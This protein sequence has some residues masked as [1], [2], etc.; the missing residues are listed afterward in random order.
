[1]FIIG[2]IITVIILCIL[3]ILATIFAKIFLKMPRIFDFKD[4]KKT[5]I[6]SKKW[7]DWLEENNHKA[8]YNYVIPRKIRQARYARSHEV[9]FNAIIKEHYYDTDIAEH[10]F[11]Q[12]TLFLQEEPCAKHYYKANDG[13]FFCIT[14]RLGKKDAFSNIP[15]KEMKRILTDEPALYMKY[16]AGADQ[17]PDLQAYMKKEENRKKAEAAKAQAEEQAKAQA[18]AEAA[19]EETAE[20][21]KKKNTKNEEKK[22]KSGL[23]NRFSDLCKKAQDAVEEKIAERKEEATEAVD[24]TQKNGENDTSENL[25]VENKEE[26]EN[27]QAVA[28]PSDNASSDTTKQEEVP[29]EAE[30]GQEQEAAAETN[31]NVEETNK[32]TEGTEDPNA[33]ET[34]HQK[35]IAKTEN[36]EEVQRFDDDFDDEDDDLGAVHTDTKVD[37]SFEMQNEEKARKEREEKAAREIKKKEK[38]ERTRAYEAAK[39]KATA[40]AASK[41]IETQKSEVTTVVE[42][43]QSNDAARGENNEVSASAKPKRERR[44][45]TMASSAEA[46]GNASIGFDTNLDKEE[47]LQAAEENMPDNLDVKVDED[48]MLDEVKKNAANGKLEGLDIVAEMMPHSGK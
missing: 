48:Q 43:G 34:P 45:V 26:N 37:Q 17:N 21:L 35:D 10:F 16:I 3:V 41:N 20:P 38:E 33:Q 12:Y 9:H 24:T 11:V 42:K 15:E 14:A 22:E 25:P 47:L 6:F 13:T 1:M 30:A 18:E 44:K 31:V 2:L 39:A 28:E 23:L 29:V 19:A 40:E 8:I 46:T 27:T 5:G 7:M 36:L 4:R 32:E